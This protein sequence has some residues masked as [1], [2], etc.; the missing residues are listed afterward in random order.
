MTMREKVDAWVSGA[1]IVVPL[2]ALLVFSAQAG[3]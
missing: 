1:I 3:S 2:S